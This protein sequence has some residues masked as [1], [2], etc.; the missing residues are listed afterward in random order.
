[1]NILNMINDAL[2]ELGKQD[3]EN[4]EQ[5]IIYCAKNEIALIRDNPYINQVEKYHKINNII[6][7]TEELLEKQ[8]QRKQILNIASILN[9]LS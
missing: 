3:I 2:Q 9:E 5:I 4:T 1:M 8:K 7:K 6:L